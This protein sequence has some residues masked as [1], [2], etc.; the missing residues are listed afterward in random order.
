MTDTHAAR[1]SRVEWGIPLGWAR[2]HPLLWKDQLR[3][4]LRNVRAEGLTV[5]TLFEREWCIDIA[6]TRP[7]EPVE[8][9]GL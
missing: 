9:E 8:Y 3:R 4:F 6:A 7:G 1:T 2:Q 5:I